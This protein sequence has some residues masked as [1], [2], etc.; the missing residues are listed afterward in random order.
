MSNI[1]LKNFSDYFHE[2]TSVG[3]NNQLQISST[4]NADC[5]FCSNKQNPFK[6]KRCGFRPLEEI[7]SVLW[8]M[9]DILYDSVVLGESLPGRISEGEALL[10]PNIF[11]ILKMI[12]NKYKDQIIDISTNGTL[13]TDDFIKKL[14]EFLPMDLVISIPSINKEFWTESFNL[15][16]NKYSIV[17]NSIGKLYEYGFSIIPALVPMPSWVGYKDLEETVKFFSDKNLR[18]ILVY[19]PGYTKFTEKSVLDKL[20]YDKLELAYFFEKC[21]NLYGVV[22]NWRLYPKKDLPVCLYKIDYIASHNKSDLNYCFTSTSAYDRIVEKAEDIYTEINVIAVENKSYGGNIECTGLWMVDDIKN[23][24]DELGITKSNIFLP[25]NFLDMYGFDLMGNSFIN[26][27]KT[28]DNKFFA[29]K[30]D[31]YD[32]F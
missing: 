21:E 5:I 20:Q 31:D 15:D 13:L 12:R 1:P 32:T 11:E 8:S 4:C 6:V 9:P 25:S 28:T 24:V 26:Y 22:F 2:N 14:S 18:K 29:L 7:E 30:R 3:F 27:M 16:E 10:H 23:K 19:A 17:M